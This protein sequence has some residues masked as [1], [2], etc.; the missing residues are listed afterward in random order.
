MPKAGIQL[1]ERGFLFSTSPMSL[2]T[3]QSDNGDVHENVAEKQTSHPFKLFGNY[4][5]SPCYFKRMELRLEL[6]RGER[7]QVP[8]EEV[9]FITLPF[10]FLRKL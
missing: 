5:K 8:T 10:P 7:V 4:S 9:E 2:G 1:G 3:L 6:R